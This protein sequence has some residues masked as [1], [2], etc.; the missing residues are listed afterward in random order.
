[1]HTGQAL[2]VGVSTEVASSM[3]S[4]WPNREMMCINYP[5]SP[6]GVR[7]NKRVFLLHSVATITGNEKVDQWEMAEQNVGQSKG[8]AE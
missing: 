3:R 8:R 1:M 6:S 2:G 4:P 5:K 7:R